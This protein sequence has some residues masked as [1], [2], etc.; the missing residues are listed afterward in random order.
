MEWA[1]EHPEVVLKLARLAVKSIHGGQTNMGP[2]RPDSVFAAD[3]LGLQL[4]P[5]GITQDA[6]TSKQ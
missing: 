6:G 2:A 1:K 5:L 3:L 4:F